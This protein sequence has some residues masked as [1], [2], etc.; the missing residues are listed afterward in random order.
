[1]LA[2]KKALIL[3]H[4]LWLEFP[5]L[6][7]YEIKDIAKAIIEELIEKTPASHCRKLHNYKL[8]IFSLSGLI[9]IRPRSGKGE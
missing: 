7:K 9:L 5:E 4:K 8:M 6:N 2:S 1:M 3:C